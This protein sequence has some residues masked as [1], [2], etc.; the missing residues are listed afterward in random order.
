ME[1]MLLLWDELD[2]WTGACRHLA[3]ST[4]S[5]IAMLT[6]PLAALGSSAVAIWLLVPQVWVT[7]VTA[8][9]AAI[10]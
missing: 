10:Y 3:M 2:D 6:A 8:G 5:E 1:R 7:A 4:V 9:L